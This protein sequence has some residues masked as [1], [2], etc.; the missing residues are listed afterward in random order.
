MTFAKNIANNFYSKDLNEVTGNR[1]HTVSFTI[2]IGTVLQSRYL[3]I[4]GDQPYSIAIDAGTAEGNEEYLA[5]SARYFESEEAMTT[6]TTLLGLLPFHGSTSGEVIHKMLMKFLF[7]GPSGELRK[8]NLIGISTDH[9]SNMI[10]GG[11]AG[12]TERLQK[13]IPHLVVTHD[14]CHAFNLIVEHC[15]ESFPH[16]Y[17]NI[18]SE[19]STR[20]SM[21]PLQAAQ[22]KTY[23]K[24]KD[25]AV[26][27]ITRYVPTRWTSFVDTLDR[28]LDLS[29]QLQGFFSDQIQLKKSNSK[30]NSES[31]LSPPNLM[32]LNLLQ[33]LLRKIT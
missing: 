3:Q 30:K 9:A 7:D 12:A 25:E 14:L 6:R 23:L 18:V 29:A 5:I 24:D 28:I 11:N 1:N 16:E 15:L 26:L 17:R 31:Y 10:S 2:A 19:I 32:M 4:L 13:D 27:T 8:R 33:M 22:L 20:F 21:S